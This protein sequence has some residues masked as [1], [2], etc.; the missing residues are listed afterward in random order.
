LLRELGARA[1]AQGRTVLW[2]SASELEREL[3]FW[4]F[5]DAL[6]EYL[7]GLDPR[8]LA[9]LDEVDRA[10]LGHVF[11]S[12]DA[13]A[14]GVGPGLQDERFRT[15]RAVRQLFELLA[16]PKPLVLVL[17][18]VHWADAAN[19]EL[20]GSLLRS[21]PA[22]AVL[23][24]IAVRPRQLPAQLSGT[25]ERAIRTGAMSR[26][27]LGALSA[28]DR[29]PPQRPAR[30]HVRRRSGLLVPA[31]LRDPHRHRRRG[32]GT[33]VADARRGAARG[34]RRS[35]RRLGLLALLL[36]ISRGSTWGWTS[37]PTLA[38]FAAAL[39]LLAAFA[40]VEERVRQPLVNLGLVVTRPFASANLC[41]FAF[42]YSF[43]IA[44]F[45]IPQMAAAP[46]S[47]GYGL[48]LSTTGIGLVLLPTGV[49][50]LAGGVAG[51]RAIEH[52]GPR[53][54]VAS[55]AALGIAGYTFLALAHPSPRP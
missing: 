22:A 10:Q 53:S 19:V 2:G 46:A 3:P 28:A 24:A 6:D 5:V 41:A 18:D 51:G 38:S 17:D 31:R 36:A 44:V 55:G 8:R 54:L 13:H 39:A 30:R 34:R 32:A 7:E 16:V 47:T 33:R 9:A 25:L 49:A 12:F 52:V 23:I 20:L 11:P 26:V 14:A 50:S 4:V 45:V 40:L 35:A 1:D 42:G 29:L 21:P 48:D 43:F 27:E 15:H 37:G